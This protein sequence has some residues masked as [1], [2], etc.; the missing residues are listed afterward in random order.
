MEDK[1]PEKTDILRQV[2]K[3]IAKAKKNWERQTVI[4]RSIHAI[5]VITAIISSLIVAS[6]WKTFDTEIKYFGFLAALT[7]GLSSALDIGS[8]ANRMR[9]AWRRLNVAIIKFEEKLISMDELIKIYGESEE[10][11]GDVKELRE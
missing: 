8:K 9:R 3:E 7:V 4:L 1:I 6:E 10:I 2:P 5:L 11:I